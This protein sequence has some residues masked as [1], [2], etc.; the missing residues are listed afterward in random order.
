MIK[1]YSLNYALC[2][3]PLSHICQILRICIFLFIDTVSS[4]GKVTHSEVIA[5][6]EKKP[7]I[8]AEFKSITTINETIILTGNHLV[9]ARERFSTQF[10]PM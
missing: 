8:M 4:T 3:S 10:I 5:F 2:F 1:I 6:L 9:F 7:D